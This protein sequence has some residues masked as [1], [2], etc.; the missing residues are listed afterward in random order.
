MV[1]GSQLPYGFANS[2]QFQQFGK[3]VSS[4]LREVAG[5]GAQAFLGGSAITGRSF[6]TGAAFDVGR[7]SD[8]DIAIVGRNLLSRAKELGIELRGKGTRTGP[9]RD[10]A[11]QVLGLDKLAQRLSQQAGRPVRFM[12]YESEEELRRRGAPYQGLQ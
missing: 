11:L 5:E 6:A 7:T 12:I 1:T 10:E 4:G 3:I 8:F 2:G 9:L